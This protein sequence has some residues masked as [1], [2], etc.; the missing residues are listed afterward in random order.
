MLFAG[1]LQN[2]YGVG[3]ESQDGGDPV[4]KRGSVVTVH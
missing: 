2:G 1:P 3:T 4:L